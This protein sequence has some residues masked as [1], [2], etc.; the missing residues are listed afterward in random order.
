MRAR[1]GLACAGI[2]FEIR[3]VVLRHKPDAL[4]AA[5]AKGTV[6]VLLLQEATPAETVLDESLDIL[7][8]ALA[9]SDPLGWLAFPAQ[10]RAEMASLV[11]YND[12]VFKAH[13]DH[14]KYADR[15]PAQSA[16]HYRQQGE[17][18]LRQLDERLY[19]QA[20]LFGTQCSYADIAVL[21]FIRQFANVDAK[22]FAEAPYVHLRNW[23]QGLLNSRLFLSIMAKYP[24]W[25]PGDEPLVFTPE[26]SSLQVLE[27]PAGTG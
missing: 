5:S 15:Y 2:E 27:E 17:V 3:E 25:Q 18:F 16:L 1:M 20:W 7:L 9:Q 13:L 14:Y 23:L 6:P 24:A 4:L 26:R 10:Q 8:W 12:E 11:T 22:W 19:D 21:P